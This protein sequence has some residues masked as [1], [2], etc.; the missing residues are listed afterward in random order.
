MI[1]LE[2]YNGFSVGVWGG[3]FDDVRSVE[4]WNDFIGDFGIGGDF[5]VEDVLYG[6][7]SIV[8]VINV[9]V[10]VFGV[11]SF[12]DS[13]VV[14]WRI[15]CVFFK[16]FNEDC[17]DYEV[18]FVEGWVV[19]GE[20]VVGVLDDDDIE[21]FGWVVVGICVV[22]VFLSGEIIVFIILVGIIWWIFKV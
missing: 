22:E 10:V 1:L 17:E 18:V 9:N 8:I 6:I 21:V 13:I 16:V 3:E 12:V 15:I 19:F 4:F 11:I 5:F 7:S 20:V 14:I 2:F